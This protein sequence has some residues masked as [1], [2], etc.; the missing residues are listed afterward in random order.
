[1]YVPAREYV[2][3]FPV[4]KD[5]RC[6]NSCKYGERKVASCGYDKHGYGGGGGDLCCS[7][8]FGYGQLTNSRGYN[9]RHRYPYV[10]RSSN[11]LLHGNGYG[12]HGYGYGDYGY[13]GGSGHGYGNVVYSHG[14]SYGKNFGYGSGSVSIGS[15]YG[16][17]N[18]GSGYGVRYISSGPR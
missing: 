10:A 7:T 18:I 3:L 15:G 14:P 1:M 13:H 11:R 9:Y 5:C 8:R 6:R 12:D 4:G 17:G 2:W 16:H